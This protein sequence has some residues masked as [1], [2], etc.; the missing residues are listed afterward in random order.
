MTTITWV[1]IA[2]AYVVVMLVAL[3]ICSANGRDVDE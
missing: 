1:T 3:A 2:A